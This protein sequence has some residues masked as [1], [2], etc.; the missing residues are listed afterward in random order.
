MKNTKC[1]STISRSSNVIPQKQTPRSSAK[2]LRLSRR[3][4][5]SLL[6]H[7]VAEFA[8]SG[9]PKELALRAGIRSVTAEEAKK[10][11]GFPI[12]PGWAAPHGHPDDNDK[13][14]CVKPD[15][16][17]EF[18]NG[19]KAK[20]VWPKDTPNKLFF[21]PG[22][23]NVLHDPKIPLLITEGVKKSLCALAHG[24]WV[25]SVV[26]CW[27]W[28]KK[29]EVIPDLKRLNVQQ[30]LI[31][32]VYDSDAATKASVE[33]GQFRLAVALM[34][35]SAYVKIVRLPQR[36]PTEKNGLDDFFVSHG[37][38]EFDQLLG[39]ALP[40]VEYELERT[41]AFPPEA[42]IPEI[43]RL[44]KHVAEDCQPLLQDRFLTA[45]HRRFGM[46]MSDLRRQLRRSGHEEYSTEATPDALNQIR[47][48]HAIPQEKRHRDVS[49]LVRKDLQENGRF[50]NSSRGVF[51][52]EKQSGKLFDVTQTRFAAFCGK[53]YGTNA[54]NQEW[55]FVLAD[56]VSQTM[57]ELREV[58]V[59]TFAYFKAETKTLYVAK[60]E[61]S[62]WKLDGRHIAEVPMGCDDVFLQSDTFEAPA[63]AAGV[64]ASWDEH[65]WSLL[66]LD[67]AWGV[68][69]EQARLLLKV[70]VWSIFFNEILTTRPILSLVGP[71]GSGKTTLLKIIGEALFG[72][73]FTVNP[74]PKQH[75]DLETL[76]VNARLVVLDNNDAS[77]HPPVLDLMAIVAT[78]GSISRR[79][80][81]TTGDLAVFPLACF[82]AMTSHT[83][84]FKRDDIA[85]R[86]LVLGTARV[87]DFRS[88]SSLHENVL[89]ARGALWWEVLQ[90]LNRIVKQLRTRRACKPITEHRMADFA[91]FGLSALQMKEHKA[92]RTALKA[93][94]TSRAHFM[95]E[96]D[97][98][99][100]ALCTWLAKQSSETGEMSAT[101]IHKAMRGK[102]GIPNPSALGK[103]LKDDGD[104]LRAFVHVE[105]RHLEGRTLYRLRLTEVGRKHAQK[106][107]E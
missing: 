11:V 89:S 33:L 16:P 6:P 8:A 42:H 55:R 76:L 18:A 50:L 43:D 81:Y 45:I 96:K 28:Q 88:E 79:R 2:V 65:V 57:S 90:E 47:Y 51:Y 95:L 101:D 17:Y 100:P 24:H 67:P 63:V 44:L 92:W 86:L 9:V 61:G 23:E 37:K 41:A 59:G 15:S 97:R 25:L 19:R 38:N 1:K 83:P 68:T 106:H 56:I 3:R 78:G 66:S 32:I 80:L 85:E 4:E 84:H 91:N 54:S 75:D 98:V 71:K 20:Y 13:A 34:G 58:K 30:R 74:M 46:R 35:R 7:H 36:S 5:S 69:R 27:N 87:K 53:H 94:E 22:V 29:R 77:I 70:W 73:R 64:K 12:G 48:Q 31:Y 104:P 39:E 26:G 62:L 49:M 102:L 72:R 60:E 105:Y 99:V 103:R 52:L 107:E 93:L 82:L 40:L 10:M 21:P 14:W